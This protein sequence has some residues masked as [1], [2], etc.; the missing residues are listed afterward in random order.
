VVRRVKGR[1]GRLCSYGKLETGALRAVSRKCRRSPH[2]R[3][4]ASASRPMS[5]P[6]AVVPITRF[7][8]NS[9][10]KRGPT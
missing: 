4:T 8:S 1:D 3:D 6:G 7:K 10:R 5:N 2:F 9:N